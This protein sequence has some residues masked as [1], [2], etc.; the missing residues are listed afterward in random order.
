M[1]KS[2]LSVVEQKTVIFYDDELIA[3]RSD[4][5]QVYV[6]L[7]QMC[8]AL[9]LDPQAQTR[10]I[11][12][13][14]ILSDG[15]EGVDKLAT[16]GGA[17]KAYVLRVDLVPL[18]LSGIRTSAVKE[19]IR[20]KMEKYQREA[21]KVLWEAFQ[22]GRLTADAGFDELLDN[23]S[24]AAQAYKMATAVMKMARQQL[25]LESQ[26]ASHTTLLSDHERRLEF[27]EEQLGDTGRYIT[28]DQASQISQAVKTVAMELGKRSKKNEYG[29]VYGQMYRK[30]GITGYKQLPGSQFDAA[31]RWL[32]EWYQTITGAMGNEVPF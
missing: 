1:K 27:I 19:E 17:Q 2:E 25:L 8:D 4:E 26:L 23:D 9:G 32:T 5:G 31:M 12:R 15:L 22:E 13:H 30:F 18:W 21:A 16:P 11:D 20:A 6:S 29:S 28:P 3:I 7:R 10:R 14:T 24:P